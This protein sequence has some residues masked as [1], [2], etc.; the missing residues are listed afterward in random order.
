MNAGVNLILHFKNSFKPHNLP[1]QNWQTQGT[2]GGAHTL[3]TNTT[4]REEC[5]LLKF[6]QH[7]FAPGKA[8]VVFLK[9]GLC[10]QS[11][12][13]KLQSWVFVQRH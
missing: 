2:W 8:A 9:N 6:P 12:P 13:E 11:E 1:N 4:Q 7:N 10:V 5:Q 3:I